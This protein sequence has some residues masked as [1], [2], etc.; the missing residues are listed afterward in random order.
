MTQMN[1]FRKPIQECSC[2]PMTG[3][4]RDGTCSTEQ[5]D[6]GEHVVC[7]VMTEE[8]L[9]F[10]RYVG[11]DLSTPRLDF[12]FPGLKPGD[13]WCL[14]LDRWKQALE[15]GCAPLVDLQATHYSALNKV[16]LSDLESHAWTQS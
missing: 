2:Q 9:A 11:N 13:H 16:S 14:C 8:F 5:A 6:R 3:W 1:V 15:A 10:S 4:F 12:G 7:C